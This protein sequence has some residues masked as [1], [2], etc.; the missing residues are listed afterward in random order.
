MLR[1]PPSAASPA[2]E[3]APSL[4]RC[5]N[6]P[7]RAE[8]FASGRCTPQNA[9]IQVRNGRLN[10]AF[11]SRNP[12]CAEG[13]LHDL[14]WERRAI[15]VRYAPLEAIGELI[16]DPDEVVRRAVA[17]R[18]PVAELP[19]LLGDPDREVRVTLASRLPAE[20]LNALIED[21]DYLVRLLVAQRLPL[22]E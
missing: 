18:L 19:A 3:A 14:F 20:H 6:C 16:D 11:L 12:E 2:S 22:G 5:Q 13:C 10:D 17:S 8:R 1:P 4:T 21:P 9:C 15:A 7:H